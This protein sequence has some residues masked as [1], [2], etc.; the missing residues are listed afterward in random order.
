MEK[1][2]YRY[3]IRMAFMGT[4]FNGWQ[5]QLTSPSIQAETERALRILL[6]DEAIR[7]T[8]AG[9]TDTGVHAKMFYAH[10]DT[11]EYFSTT[12][13]Q[14]ILYKCNR[15]L[16]A[17]IAIYDIFP[18]HHKAH[19]RFHASQR[20]YHYYISTQKD[21]FSID[22]AWIYERDLDVS[23]MQKASDILLR[24]RDFSS[25]ARSNTQVKTHICHVMV[26]K[27]H[28]QG[29]LLR[30]EITADR[31]LRNMVRAIT[32]TLTEVGTGK[33][34]TE[35]FASII[36]SRDRGEAGY[37]APACGLYLADIQYPEAIL[38]GEAPLARQRGG[39]V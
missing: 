1:T 33:I 8:G 19:A 31:F 32:G 10:F 39:R 29:H 21:P 15:I 18:V 35:D 6:K 7:V 27:W 34:S 3:F 23:G 36:E 28:S 25:F 11:G 22:R 9:R 4:D 5:V 17:S 37:S 24:Y 12:D 2:H 30:F 14:Q 16:P 13:L 20:T 26:A 38:R